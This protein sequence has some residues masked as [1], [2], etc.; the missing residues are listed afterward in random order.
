[1]KLTKEDIQFIDNYLDNSDVIYADIR[2]E[3]VDHVASDIESRMK[4]GDTRGF[5]YVFKD[6]MVENKAQLLK[7][8]RQFLKSAD[9]KIGQTFLKELKKPITP[10]LFLASCIGYYVLYQN[11][12]LETFRAC[13][14][15]VPLIGLTGFILTYVF[16]QGV[17]D[18][19]RF[20]VV[21]RL[22]FPFLAFYQLPNI[23]LIRTRE[24]N[25]TSDLFWTIG[26]ASLALTL[27]LVLVI[28]SV[29]LFMSYETRFKNIA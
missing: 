10:L 3:M 22:A 8:N 24:L 25:E 20:S 6:Y 17:K 29:K 16:Y 4:S 7:E 19:K 11:S 5:Y 27:M 2:M 15:I 12:N 1:M 13:L 28:I 18:N 21:E 26:G 14:S 9:K 23:F